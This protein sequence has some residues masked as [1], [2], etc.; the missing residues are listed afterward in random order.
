MST[1][2]ERLDV[3][4]RLL[5]EIQEDIKKG[6]IEHFNLLVNGYLLY[7]YEKDP[8]T[9]F[10]IDSAG[11]A[12]ARLRMMRNVRLSDMPKL[13]QDE[14]LDF[15]DSQPS[16]VTG[17]QNARDEGQFLE[18]ITFY[19]AAHCV[20]DHFKEKGEKVSVYLKTTPNTK[21]AS[22]ETYKIITQAHNEK[23]FD[24]PP[25]TNSYVYECISRFSKF[26]NH[27]KKLEKEHNEPKGKLDRQVE[28]LKAMA[29]KRG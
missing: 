13:A 2:I 3:A 16:Y 8:S 29:I 22:W 27:M 15:I 4:R 7:N 23:F 11:E 21:N 18:D 1:E 19:F 10:N 14:I 17:G 26:A 5:D 9:K 28:A 24:L 20:K 6:A 25:V 12:V